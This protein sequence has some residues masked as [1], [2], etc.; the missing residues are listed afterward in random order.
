MAFFR[1]IIVKRR[2]ERARERERVNVSERDEMR[3]ERECN[4]MSER[5][6]EKV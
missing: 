2:E 1:I 3:C 6:R 5:E 4:E